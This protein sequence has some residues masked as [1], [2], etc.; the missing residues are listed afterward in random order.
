MQ[1]MNVF[2]IFFVFF[3]KYRIII[4][5]SC[6]DKIWKIYIQIFDYILIRG[7]I[8]KGTQI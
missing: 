3:I 8:I 7:I 5:L 6:Y 1:K 4:I 2:S